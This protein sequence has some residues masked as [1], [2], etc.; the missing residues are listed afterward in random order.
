MNQEIGL[1]ATAFGSVQLII[2]IAYV[3]FEIQVTWQWKS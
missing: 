3:I 1:T 2:F